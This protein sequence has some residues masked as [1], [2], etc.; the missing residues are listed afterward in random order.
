[1]ER[2]HPL[3]ADTD[4]SPE[5]L[6]LAQGECALALGR[7]DGLLA[8][9]TDTEKRLFCVGLLRAV[10]LSALAQA[11]FADAEHR[12]NAWFAGLDRGPQETPLTA[13][14]A[15]AVVRA[16][17]GELSHHPWEPLADAAQTIALAARFGADRPMQAEDAL[18]EEAIGRAITLAKRAGADDEPPLPFAGLAR[19][20][21]LLRA[22]P[23][24]APLER[25]VRSFS[26]GGREVAVEQAAP[27]TPLWAVDAALGRLLSASGTWVHAL[28]CAGAVTTEALQPQLWPGERALL[29]ARGLHVSVTRL[30]ELVVQARRRAA[31]MREQLGHLRSSA[32]A[33]QV[34]ILLAG[35]APLG[36]DQM[37]AA[38]GISRRGTYAIGNALVA[39]RMA[40]R[41][42]VK[43][44]VLLVAEEP[45]RDWQPASLDQA[46]ALPRAALAEF[47]AAMT[48]IDQLLA[49]SSGPG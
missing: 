38:F 34:W 29:A 7:L 15:Y 28:P 22:D 27:R 21:A 2:F 25:A 9:L 40:R 1:M 46:T 10:L 44:K 37:A 49:R 43:G 36:L 13:C 48:D 12:F 41:E 6:A 32:R 24:F 31:L 17:L 14:S 19:L 3:A 35:F 30:C 16:L 18:A 8:S 20:H 23:L 33:P 39:A 4:A 47:D 11:G 5:E 42:T 26:F 45:R